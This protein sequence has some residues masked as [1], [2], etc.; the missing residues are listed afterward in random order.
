MPMT[1]GY[2]LLTVAEMR[3]HR[4]TYVFNELHEGSISD[5]HDRMKK[6][7]ESFE[8][9]GKPHGKHCLM[10]AVPIGKYEYEKLKADWD[11]NGEP[12]PV[13]IWSQSV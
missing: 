3:R 1:T 4:A 10:S 12:D 9:R 8:A 13:T 7:Y 5:W 2:W 11:E 6:V